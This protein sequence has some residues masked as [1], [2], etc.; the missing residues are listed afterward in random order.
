M[1]YRA[2]ADEARL[3][4]MEVKNGSSIVFILPMPK[5]WSEKKKEQMNNEPHLQR[6]DLDNLLKA[7][8]DALM[9]ED[10]VIW[11][12]GMLEKRWGDIGLIT[13]S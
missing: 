3:L 9:K 4:K 11:K 7:L 1:R 5:S 8:L 2:F 12:L 10:S 13:I 6:P